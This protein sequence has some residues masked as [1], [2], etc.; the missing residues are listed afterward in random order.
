[1]RNYAL[2]IVLIS[3]SINPMVYTMQAYYSTESQLVVSKEVLCF[4]GILR[5]VD[6]VVFVE[7]IQHFASFDHVQT[8]EL[9]FELNLDYYV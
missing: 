8:G 3:V 5:D 1:M 2:T 9:G 6:D 7:S 4:D